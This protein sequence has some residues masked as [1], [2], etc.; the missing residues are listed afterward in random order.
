MNITDVYNNDINESILNINLNKNKICYYIN[1]R[2]LMTDKLIQTANNK[3]VDYFYNNVYEIEYLL[4]KDIVYKSIT[5][6]DFLNNKRNYILGKSIINL[7][8]FKSLNLTF[9]QRLGF[10]IPLFIES[11]LNMDYMSAYNKYDIKLNHYQYIDTFIFMSRVLKNFKNHFKNSLIKN[12][13]LND[14]FINTNINLHV[15]NNKLYVKNIL[16]K[17][18]ISVYKNKNNF[19]IN[20]SYIQQKYSLFFD[21]FSYMEKNNTSAIESNILHEMLF[22]QK[23]IQFDKYDYLT[24]NIIQDT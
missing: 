4:K 13:K 6:D 3:F 11:P 10:H 23:I 1:W 12:K 18:F 2:C 7:K 14:L 17:T 22:S 15:I 16:I 5:F 20:Y 24:Q 9:R 19:K 21:L 8:M